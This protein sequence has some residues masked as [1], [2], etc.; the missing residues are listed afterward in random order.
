MATLAVLVS[1]L[2]MGSFVSMAFL[3]FFQRKTV[4]GFIYLIIGIVAIVLFY[5]GADHGWIPL[6][7]E[8]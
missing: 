1:L 8:Q 3:R 6:P 7:K 5:V 2:V 4:Q